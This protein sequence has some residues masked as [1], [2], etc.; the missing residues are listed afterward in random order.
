MAETEQ[1]RPGVDAGAGIGALRGY[2]LVVLAVAVALLNVWIASTLPLWSLQIQRDKESELI[3][4]GLQYAEGIRIFQQ[5]YNR[6]PTSLKELVEVEPRCIRQLWENP[7]R[8]D[9]RWGLIPVGVGGEIGRAD[10]AGNPAGLG[11]GGRGNGGLGARGQ[12]AQGLGARGGGGD[13]ESGFGQS[14]FPGDG[15]DA[16]AGVLLSADPDDSFGDT[17]SS[18]SIRGVFSPTAK[19]SVRIFDG[20][21]NVREWQFTVELVS[22]QKQGLPDNPGLVTPFLASEIGRPFPPGVMP[23]VPQPSSEARPQQQG[24]N[25]GEGVPTNDAGNPIIGVGG[26]QAAPTGGGSDTPGT[27]GRPSSDG[28]N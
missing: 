9:G 26:G 8:E 13:E 27:G 25:V 14:P 6:Y 7:M 15:E 24:Q 11:D 5:R 22:A 1:R 28:R 20:K 21:E 12:G 10:G 3:F 2:N 23:Q 4:R 18:V 19:E 17:P 16:N